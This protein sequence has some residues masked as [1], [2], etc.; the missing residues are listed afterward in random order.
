MT[1][2]EQK[3]GQTMPIPNTDRAAALAASRA[4]RSARTEALT[5]VSEGKLSPAEVIKMAES[6]KAIARMRPERLA[7]AIPTI[8]PAKAS[9]ILDEA[10]I[11]STKRIGGLGKH[12][13]A[14]LEAKLTEVYERVFG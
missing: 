4:A 1:A 14:A 3:K 8:G 9:D 5:K 13:R 2:K 12:Q 6:D 10:Q 7:R 11:A